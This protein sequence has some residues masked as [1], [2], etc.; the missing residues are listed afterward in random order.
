MVIFLTILFSCSISYAFTR[1]SYY[2][3]CQIFYSLI[4]GVGFMG[5]EPQV[6]VYVFTAK[7]SAVSF[8]D[9]DYASTA[10]F[11]LGCPLLDLPN[12]TG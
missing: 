10:N 8:Y 4:F 5:F 1:N 6:F 3:E 9:G 12:A 11:N 7:V 2:I